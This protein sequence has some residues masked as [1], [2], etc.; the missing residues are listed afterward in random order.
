MLQQHTASD[1]YQDQQIFFQIVVLERQIFAW[2]GTA[3]PRMGNLCL[4]MPTR[5][6]PVPSATTLLGS[7]DEDVTSMAQRLARRVG[8]SVA[9]SV[10][11]PANQPLM[12]AF[13][14]KRLLQE[15]QQ[16]QLV[17][18]AANLNVQA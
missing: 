7:G 10:N 18:Q 9:L 17:Q 3:P 6:D 13:V 2:A 15:M 1:V 8:R 16:L 5:L 4:A 11:L 12:R 14:E